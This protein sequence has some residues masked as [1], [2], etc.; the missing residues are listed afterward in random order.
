MEYLTKF[1]KLQMNINGDLYQ[2]K[3]EARK[4]IKEKIA[5]IKYNIIDHL[6]DLESI[7]LADMETKYTSIEQETSVI[8]Q[9]V[10][11]SL[12][13]WTKGLRSLKEHTTNFHL[14]Q[15]VKYLDK[16]VNEHEFNI[17]KSKDSN[18][19]VL[20]FKPSD[21]AVNYK[22]SFSSLGTIIEENFSVIPTS[23]LANE[24]R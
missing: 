8:S 2:R 5:E 1:I 24:Q 9:S 22:T 10:I 4:K 15:A 14:F 7:L 20:K 21:I 16:K 6:N 23:S 13:C 19:S 18:I 17:Q 12:D 3:E 11:D